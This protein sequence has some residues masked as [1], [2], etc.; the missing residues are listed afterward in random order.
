MRSNRQSIWTNS[1]LSFIASAA[2]GIL[3][4]LIITALTALFA[5]LFISD[6]RAIRFISLIPLFTGAFSGSFFCG[7]HRR[8]KGLI[9]GIICGVLLYLALLVFGI[10]FT[11]SLAGLK[12]LLLL[13]VSG[14]IGGVTGVN[15]KRPKSLR[16]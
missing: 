4:T 6:L 15:S 16:T 8:K 14:A 5:F 9:E 7:K 10:V 1:L 11:G 12:K 13:V 3:S 2:V